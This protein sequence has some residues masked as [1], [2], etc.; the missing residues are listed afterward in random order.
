MLYHNTFQFKFFITEWVNLVVFFT[1]SAVT[2]APKTIWFFQGRNIL[3]ICPKTIFMLFFFVLNESLDLFFYNKDYFI[4]LKL[5][6]WPAAVSCPCVHERACVH[7]RRGLEEGGMNLSRDS[8]VLMIPSLVHLGQPGPDVCQVG[9]TR[10]SVWESKSQETVLRVTVKPSVSWWGQPTAEFW[11]RE[12]QAQWW[13]P[14]WKPRCTMITATRRSTW[15][16]RRN[17]TGTCCWTLPGNN[18]RGK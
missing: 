4:D 18:N 14:R 17:G 8:P 15:Y 2:S 1:K 7:S 13:W 16:R 5:I 11:G 6:K 10:A 12:N 3:F 9:T